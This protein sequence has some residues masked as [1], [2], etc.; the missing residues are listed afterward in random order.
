MSKKLIALLLIAMMLFMTACGGPQE[1]EEPAN[2]T[3]VVPIT[4]VSTTMDPHYT[5]G[6]TANYF[7]MQ[8]VFETPTAHGGDGVAYPLICDYTE[9]E[10]LTE[11]T[12]TVR[13]YYFHNGDRVTAEDVLASLERA[14]SVGASWHN[15][16]WC[17]ITETKIE[18][19][20]IYL[21][22]DTPLVNFIWE[23][24]DGRGPCYIMPKEL[25]E[26][27]TDGAQIETIEDVIGTGPYKLKSYNPDV[28]I[29]VEKFEDYVPTDNGKVGAFAEAKNAYIPNIRW[30]RNDDAASRTAGL[31]A[32]DYHIGS[33]VEEME[34]LVLEAG[35]KK[36]VQY[37][38]W[39]HAIFFN[40]DESNADSPVADVNFRKAIRA[41]LDNEGVMLGI[42][43]GD[44]TRFTMN[45]SPIVTS[46]TNYYNDIIESTEWNIN[47]KELAKEYLAKTDYNGEP[48]VW[49]V[50]SGGAFYNAAM[51]AIPMLEEVG[52]NVDLQ[53][54]DGGSHGA[55]RRDPATGHD[56][57]AWETQKVMSNP[58]VSNSLVTG[59]DG[60]WWT[61]E[62]KT[63]YIDI[64]KSTP[65]GSAESI[66]AYKDFCTL[67]TEEVPWIVFGT[68]I[69]ST[70]TA[71]NI[72]LGDTSMYNLHF[73]T[74]FVEE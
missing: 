65:T 32:G 26:K 33:I 27:Y 71:G 12:L 19:D 48:I 31:I 18:G 7:W 40:L 69:G 6:G 60:G 50:N 66:Q 41:A 38:D 37:T 72:E 2:D 28:A 8:Y 23:L 10:D 5:A 29:E 34:D 53:V 13:E 73:N 56:I 3:L 22:A 14:D 74:R 54:V 16:F 36:V 57:G 59:I 51:A 1:S 43:G 4:Y 44:P 35:L 58:S 15:N 70:W 39:T 11:F 45:S 21:K 42:R 67:V 63:E 46:N 64:M 49:L 24:G 47:N 61:H 25:C 62:K 9:S 20:T 52:I 55:M 17:H 30:E 68:A